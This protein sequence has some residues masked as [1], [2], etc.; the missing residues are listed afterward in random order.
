MTYPWVLSQGSTLGPWNQDFWGWSQIWILQLLPKG[1]RKE[2]SQQ[3]SNTPPKANI[4]ILQIPGSL[5]Q[6]GHNHNSEPTAW[7]LGWLCIPR[8]HN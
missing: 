7:E 8:F 6:R 5:S 3:R 2:V 1:L 4:P